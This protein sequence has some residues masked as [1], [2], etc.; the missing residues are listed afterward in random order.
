M[1]EIVYTRDQLDA[2]RDWLALNLNSIT[3]EG[4]YIEEFETFWKNFFVPSITLRRVQERFDYIK[5]TLNTGPLVSWF[6]WLNDKFLMYSFVNLNLSIHE[7]SLQANISESNISLKL[8]DYYVER[9]PYL[10][11][12]LNEV[13]QISNVSNDNLFLR[14]SDIITSFAIENN[15]TVSWDDDLM[16]SLEVTLYPEWKKLLIEI[17][18]VFYKKKTNIIKIRNNMTFAKQLKF[19]QEVLILFLVGS[20][21]LFSI[22]IGNKW[23][24]DSMAGKISLFEPNFFWLDKSLTFREA[25]NQD[26]QKIELSLAQID[27]LEKVEGDQD[28]F[29]GIEELRFDDESDVTITSVESLPKNFEVA[30]Q[31]Q[32]SYEEE[33]KGGFRDQKVGSGRAFRVMMNS[34]SP[35]DARENI[36]KLLDLYKAEQ[37]DKVAPGKEIPG[38]VYY[39]L[40]VPLGNLREFL[41]RID[42]VEKTIIYESKTRTKMPNG[43]AKVFVWIKSI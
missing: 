9:Y 35:L 42:S 39:N 1:Q 18:N 38:G 32:S 6:D 22:R 36:N 17:E 31:E 3:W 26:E 4:R 34:V 41:S 40:Y 37:V 43:M 25:P 12:G 10:E 5:E 23:Y 21:L 7:L 24:E 33:T 2:F 15:S 11:E 29:E 30:S 28:P 8:R 13:F 27:E 14:H 19:F 16:G 20:F